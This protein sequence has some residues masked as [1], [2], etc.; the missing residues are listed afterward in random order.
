MY[1]LKFEVSSIQVKIAQDGQEGLKI[2]RLFKPDLLLLDIKIPTLGGEE[3]LHHLQSSHDWAEHMKV[4]ILSN[5]N[6]NVA[7][8]K[9]HRLKVDRYLVKAHYTPTQIIE[10]VREI[11]GINH[12]LYA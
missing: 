9:L 1:R 12:S 4:I 2:A 5:V 6:R 8:Q 7:P 11:L 10:I 3:V